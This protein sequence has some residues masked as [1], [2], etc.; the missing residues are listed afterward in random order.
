MG[1]RNK[2]KV[3]TVPIPNTGNCTCVKCSG[4]RPPNP[5]SHPRRRRRLLCPLFTQGVVCPGKNTACMYNAANGDRHRCG[6]IRLIHNDKNTNVWGGTGR[7]G[8][9]QSR[10]EGKHNGGL[11]ELS[12]TSNI[13]TPPPP[14]LAE[15]QASRPKPRQS[16]G[17]LGVYDKVQVFFLGIHTLT[18]PLPLTSRQQKAS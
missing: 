8:K 9:K 7:R 5:L 17:R 15:K 12:K 16:Y 10:R 2:E 1:E 3:S 14:H 6:A 13:M 11:L 18:S 4:S